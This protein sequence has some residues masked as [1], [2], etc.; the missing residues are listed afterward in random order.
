MGMRLRGIEY[1]PHSELRGY[2]HQRQ[3]KQKQQKQPTFNVA[4][5]VAS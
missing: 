5:M 4:Y 1:S 3:Q 2:N